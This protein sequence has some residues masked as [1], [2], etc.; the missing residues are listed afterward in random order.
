[1]SSYCQ[2]QTWINWRELRKEGH[3]SIMQITKMT[4]I[5]VNNDHVQWRLPIGCRWTLLLVED[6]QG[7]D[8][9]DVLEGR[10]RTGNQE[11]RGQSREFERGL[12][13]W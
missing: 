13:D 6:H 5:Q 9:N 12:N 10:E 2:S 8:N 1:M 3:P 4:F 7:Q 11:Y